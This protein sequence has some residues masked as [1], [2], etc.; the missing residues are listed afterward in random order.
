ME[1]SII[2]NLGNREINE[3][4]VAFFQAPTG[5]VFVL[6]DGLGGHGGG[7]IASKTAVETVKKVFQ[8]ND[9]DNVEIVLADAFENAH[10]MLKKLQ[11]E[12]KEEN[13]F[14]T[15]LVVLVVREN[16]YIWGNIGD[17]RLYH[18][19][20][21]ILIERSMD[22]SVP[23]M[24]VNSGNLKERKIRFHEDRSRLTKVLGADD[25]TSRPFVSKRIPITNKTSFLLCT[26]GF[27]E[28]I[29]EKDMEKALKK[30]SN[31]EEWLEMMREKVIK[32]GRKKKMDNYSAITVKL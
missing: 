29:W 2:S 25:E 16:E 21:N 7:E 8:N 14:K 10:N 20:E 31:A 12:T 30:T 18:F 3:D 23:Q 11:N 13:F 17:S 15:T 6:A 24:L 26:D 27:W 1:Y 28:L 19:E 22:H 4:Y 32:N 5:D 9:R